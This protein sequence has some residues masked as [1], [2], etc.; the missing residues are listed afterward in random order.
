VNREGSVTLG[1]IPAP[2]IPEKIANEIAE[3]LPE[4]LARRVDAT[5]SWE[6]PVLV[7]PLTGS[8]HDAPEILDVCRE[9]M[10]R[11]DWDLAICL[12]DLPVYRGGRLVA[13]DVSGQRE[14]AGISLP[15][16]GAM[17]LRT[18]VRELTLHLAHELYART[19]EPG[20]EA[21]P[22]EVRGPTRSGVPSARS[23]RP[24]RT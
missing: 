16:L 18:R 23:S 20:P 17:R 6:V 7:D 9:R 14:V 5:V 13:A 3:E 22:G 24:T 8:G 19:K 10:L 4:L 12:T 21:P 1:L 11:E 15:A 2:D